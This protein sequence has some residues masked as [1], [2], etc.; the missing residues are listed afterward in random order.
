MVDWWRQNGRRIA[1]N[2]SQNAQVPRAGFSP[3]LIGGIVKLDERS[4]AGRH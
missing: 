2:K 4:C 1:P 3:D